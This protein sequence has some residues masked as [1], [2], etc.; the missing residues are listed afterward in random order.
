[1]YFNGCVTGKMVLKITSVLVSG[2]RR[3]QARLKDSVNSQSRSWLM[4]VILAIQEAEIRRIIVR[5]QPR[6]II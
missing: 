1:M 2:G 6:H 5:N 3:I 4:P